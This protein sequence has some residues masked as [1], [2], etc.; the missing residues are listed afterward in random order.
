MEI[1]MITSRILMAG[2]FIA[3]VLASEPVSYSRA[4]APSRVVPDDGGRSLL[5]CYHVTGLY[6]R[7]VEISESEI[8]RRGR[9]TKIP[10]GIS[11]ANL[12]ERY[13]ADAIRFVRIYWRG[14][15]FGAAYQT[16]VALLTRQRAGASQMRTAILA[17][18]AAVPTVNRL[19]PS[20]MGWV[21]KA[22]A[23]GIP[24]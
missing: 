20:A 15:A 17:D 6:E 8:A 10:E 21:E 13:D 18:T 12:R 14:A 16:D 2:S 22:G 23:E 3:A 5:K 7:A 19:C 24:L 4:Q 1:W 9:W 11:G